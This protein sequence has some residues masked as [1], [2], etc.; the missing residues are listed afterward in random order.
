MLSFSRATAMMVHR[1]RGVVLSSTGAVRQ[2]RTGH[3]RGLGGNRYDYLTAGLQGDREQHGGLRPGCAASHSAEVV[4]IASMCRCSRPCAWFG[5][6]RDVLALRMRPDMAHT[7][8][9]EL[10]IAAQR[11]QVPADELPWVVC[12]HFVIRKLRRCKVCY[13]PGWRGY[14]I[15]G[16]VQCERPPPQDAVDNSRRGSACSARLKCLV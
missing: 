4:P 16:A 8:T 2:R 13:L 15:C 6:L 14:R 9:S 7:L 1:H 3:F 10:D 12:R 5:Q 11:L